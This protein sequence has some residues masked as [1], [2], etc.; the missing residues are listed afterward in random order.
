VVKWEGVL[1]SKGERLP[2]E[3]GEGLL[4]GSMKESTMLRKIEEK[5]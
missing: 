2:A 5:E 4:G 1:F 3:G